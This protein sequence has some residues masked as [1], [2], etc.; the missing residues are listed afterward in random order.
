MQSNKKR[1]AAGFR[2]RGS[3]DCARSAAIP[4]TGDSALLAL[5][6]VLCLASLADFAALLVLKKKHRS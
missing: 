2:R 1:V 6:T 4:A 3:A 5:W